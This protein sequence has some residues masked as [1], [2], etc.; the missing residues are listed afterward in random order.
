M[1]AKKR[2]RTTSFR[3]GR[4][5]DE[6]G[7]VLVL[8]SMGLVVAMIAAGLAIDIG[9]LAQDAR[10]DQKTADLSVLDAVRV[11]PGTLDQTA[12][13]SVTQVAKDAALRN[14]FNYAA[15]SY[16]LL[17]EWG[18]TK[19]GPFTAL[20]ADLAAATAV[21]VT[22]SSPH[23]NNFP[24]LGGR[25]TMSRKAV[26]TKKDIA[27]FTLGSSL[28]TVDSTTS[29]LLNPVIGKMLGGT[30]SLSVVSW[31]GLASGKVTL[32]ALRTQLAAMGF[33]VGTVSQMLSTNLTLAQ[34][35]QA[36]ANAM[37]VNGDTAN[38]SVLNTLRL[39]AISAAT[40]T[41][42]QMITVEQGAE[43]SAAAAQL[44]LLQLVAGSA[45]LANGSNLI[46]V[47]SLSLTVPNAT[48]VG[49]SLKVIEG[50]K[51]YIGT[52][53]TGPH[54]TTG[55]VEL[56]LTPQVNI[57]NL[58]GLVKVTGTFPVELHAAGATGTLKSISCPSKNIVVTVDPQAVSGVVKSSTLDVSS[59]G[60]VHLLDV[61]ETNSIS[62]AVDAPAQDVPFTY[63]ADFS[64]PNNVSKHVGSV[65]L[66]IQTPNVITGTTT[67][68]NVLGLAT[69]GL[70]TGT[71]LNGVLGALDTM[72]GD[73]DSLVL[74]PLFKALGIDIGGA[75]VTALGTDPV[76]GVGLPQCGLPGL[77][78]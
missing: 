1:S 9:T 61:N 78:S 8:A 27:G 24:F 69:L 76:S 22:T 11:L 40:L 12:A 31:Q 36:T 46:S 13:G 7:A 32:E 77:A 70:S 43:G 64:P 62:T 16:S 55:Q 20:A 33:S 37:T 41:L 52:A 47:P 42:G 25:T 65:P 73:L 28:L 48:S 53:G 75:D 39:Q 21:R 58:L 10:Q 19:T 49:L 71:V 17:V 67:N 5:R 4:E 26:A 60:L 29:S 23:K 51:T 30:L 34:L 6:G 72:V 66:G 74:T 14:G 63:S 35:Y 59:L 45:T 15:T 44:N 54:V 18:P 68:V 57:L 3:R 56:V 2:F 38:A 50:V